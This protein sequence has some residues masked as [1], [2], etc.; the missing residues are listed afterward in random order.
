[1]QSGWGTAASPA[2]HE[3]RLYLVND[4][5]EDSYL[6]ALDTKTGTEVWRS[7][8]DEKS[9]WSTPFVW[10][11]DL[12]TEIVTIGTGKVRSYDLA[13][14]L[15]WSLAGMSSITVATP[16]AQGGLL[17]F[18]SGFV[19]NFS[20]PIY[21]IR[22]GAS[23]DISLQ[24]GQTSNDWIVWRQAKAAPYNP[25]TLVYQDQLYVLLDRGLVAS[26]RS[27]DGAEIYSAQRLPK[28]GA[29][30]AS[31]WA[32]GGK[33]FCLN[34]DGVT[35]VLKAGNSFELL[36]TNTLADDDMCMATPAIAGNKLLIRSAS[37]VHCIQAT[38]SRE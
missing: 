10:K 5:E 29:F 32:Y 11:N 26:Y 27:Q 4:N 34:E 30:T 23:G 7:P 25:S 6:L 16:Y 31:P 3:E 19:M 14:Q 28:G 9:N 2:I 37:R 36:H 1:M 13:G 15:L 22:P 12:R 21:A 24:A 33:V 17:Y 18:S 38:A 8:R 20:R 35:F